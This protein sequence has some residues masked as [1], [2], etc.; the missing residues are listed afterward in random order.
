MGKAY[1]LLLAANVTDMGTMAALE[2]FAVA[3]V[4]QDRR[5]S[6]ILHLSPDISLDLANTTRTPYLI[7]GHYEGG[8][9]AFMCP[10]VGSNEAILQGCCLQSWF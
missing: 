7:A 10:A 2:E 4:G 6:L 8:E 1:C 5:I 3:A 9:A